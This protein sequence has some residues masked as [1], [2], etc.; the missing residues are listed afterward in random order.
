MAI[1]TIISDVGGVLIR[2]YDISEDVRHRLGLTRATFGPL[3]QELIKSY[4]SGKID[5]ETMWQ[6]FNDAGGE[7]VDTKENILGA[8]FQENLHPYPKVAALYRSLGVRGYRLAILSDTNK[9]HE[10]ILREAGVYEVCEDGSVF[11][12]HHTGFR[13]PDPGAFR[14]ALESLGISDPTTC[15]FIDDNAENVATA[16]ALGLHGLQ[17]EDDE[18]SIIAS[19]EQALALS[20]PKS[21]PQTPQKNTDH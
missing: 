12:S 2:N 19:I 11:L 14:Y 17:V 5:E 16:E 13:K 1:D 8:S 18:S 20:S 7:A 4:G 21:S 6:R 15:L 3:W 9:N 10:Q